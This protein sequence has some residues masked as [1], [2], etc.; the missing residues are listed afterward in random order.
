M[1]IRHIDEFNGGWFIGNF[2][3]TVYKTKL[4]E[5]CYKYHKKGE[6]W[7]AHYHEIGLEINLMISGKM[8]TQGQILGPGDIFIISPGEV[9][10]PEFLE[11][12]KIIVIK[13]PS[14]PGDKYIV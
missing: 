8:K 1:K 7:D 12:C 14:I 2:E 11:D 13:S 10:A 5:V 4:F 9:S 3:P 6:L